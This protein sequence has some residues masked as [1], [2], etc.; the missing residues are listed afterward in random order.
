MGHFHFTSGTQEYGQ[1][2]RICDE[3]RLIT[4]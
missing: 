4:V 2:E 1:G 3:G